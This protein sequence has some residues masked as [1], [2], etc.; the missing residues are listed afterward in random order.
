MLIIHINDYCVNV[1][2]YILQRCRKYNVNS[3]MGKIVYA[4]PAF[5]VNLIKSH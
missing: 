4:L 2:P 5:G 3:E 1:L